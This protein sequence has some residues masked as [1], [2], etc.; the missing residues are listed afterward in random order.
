MDLP[1]TR[2]KKDEQKANLDHKLKQELIMCI[3]A[4]GSRSNGERDFLTQ[5][6]SVRIVTEVK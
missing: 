4:A 6:E 1:M 3:T 5:L 2:V